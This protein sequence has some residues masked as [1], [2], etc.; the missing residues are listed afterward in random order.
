VL[1][2]AATDP[3][4]VYGSLLPWPVKGPTRVPGAYVVLVGGKA[5]AYLERGGRGLV[6]LSDLDGSWE[7]AAVATL[8]ALVRERRWS[9]LILQRYPEAL[10]AVL[11]AEGFTPSPRGL[12]HYGAAPATAAM[13]HEGVGPH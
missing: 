9:R 2:L 11:L 1:V 5:C 12:V 6:A 3:A 4:N 7:E 13:R 8:S 10:E